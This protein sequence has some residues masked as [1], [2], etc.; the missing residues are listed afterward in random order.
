MSPCALTKTAYLAA[1]NSWLCSGCGHPRPNTPNI[2]VTLQEFEVDGQLNFV[3]GCGI[4][5]ARTSF[6]DVFGESR[7]SRDLYIGRVL[8][9]DGSP[10]KE[11]MTFRGKR[12]LIVRGTRHASHRVCVQ[13]GRNLYFAMHPRY[14]FPV[15]A[16]DAELFESDLFGLIVRDCLAATLHISKDFKGILQER[17]K[18]LEKPKDGLPVIDF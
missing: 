8:G 17:L 7:V 16:D 4:P 3:S 6:L 11:W 1:Q 10:L 15:P 5:L 12:G 18:V 14:L 13:C 2:D 9:P